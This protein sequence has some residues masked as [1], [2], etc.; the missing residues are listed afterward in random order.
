M[1][2][3]DGKLLYPA[4]IVLPPDP[5]KYR[6]VHLGLRRILSDY[7]AHFSP[8]SIDEFV[9]NLEGYPAFQKGMRELAREIKTRIKREVG[10]WLSVSVGIAPNRFLAKTGASLHKPDG[11]DEINKGNFLDIYS[12]LA[13][14]DLCGKK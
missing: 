7:T 12:K 10:D 2:V 14:T 3:K 9:L 8:K 6:N 11:L 13:L 5:W 1:R 4:L